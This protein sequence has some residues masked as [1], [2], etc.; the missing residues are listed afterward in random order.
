MTPQK[1]KYRCK[2]K[3]C[4]EQFEKD[5]VF[6]LK[7]TIP[8]CT[9]AFLHT[10][11]D[12]LNKH[13]PIKHKLVRG[14]N[15]PFVNKELRKAIA[16]RSRLRNKANKTGEDIDIHKYKKQRN[17]VKRLSEK[18]K[19]AYFKNLN[20]KKLEMN[21]KFW[22]TFKPIFSSKYSPAEKLI[23]VE[24]NAIISD[25]ITLATTMNNYFS[26]IT[27]KL[28]II[29]WPELPNNA[30]YDSMDSVTRAVKKYENHPSIIKTKSHFQTDNI[31]EFYHIL[32]E[33]VKIKMLK[34]NGRK[35]SSG[36][37]PT[38]VLKENIG[39]YCNY[40]TDCINASINDCVFPAPLKLADVVPVF[41]KDDKT[42]KN[43]YRPI[44]LLPPLSKILERLLCDQINSF[45]ENKFSPILCGFRKGYS[46]Q[47]ALLR[48]LENWRTQLCDKCIV[49]TILCDLSKAFDTL[50]HDLIIAN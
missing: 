1:L 6:N 37:I 5:L 48:L 27:Q 47:D 7:H 39:L 14:N 11:E 8:G 26:T 49:G 32:P 30:L 3:F 24:N 36:P 25:E 22:Q 43:N 29:T 4:Q 19:K 41:K 10:F 23:L 17:Y 15:K 40:I 31:F 35:S 12:V 21:K 44:S 46:T 28:N 42:N 13:Q 38:N 33:I 20:P 9:N 16:T 2:R 34:L 18:T 50:P 45:M